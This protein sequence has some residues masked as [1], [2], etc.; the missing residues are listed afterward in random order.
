MPLRVVHHTRRRADSAPRWQLHAPDRPFSASTAKVRERRVQSGLPDHAAGRTPLVCGLNLVHLFSAICAGKHLA[1]WSCFVSPLEHMRKATHYAAALT[2]RRLGC[3][4]E[5]PSAF[6]FSRH[7]DALDM[8][9]EVENWLW[10]A[11]TFYAERGAAGRGPPQTER[12]RLGRPSRSAWAK[13]FLAHTGGRA[14]RS[15]KGPSDGKACA[16]PYEVS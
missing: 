4:G 11:C 5:D 12:P 10:C 2:L 1:F 3:R 16:P 15:G 8:S 13:V 9:H 6:D 7:I 14:P